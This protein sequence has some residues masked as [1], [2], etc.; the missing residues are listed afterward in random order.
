MG[1]LR[2]WRSTVTLRGGLMTA[3]G[4]L[5]A[6][7]LFGA[8]TEP[9]LKLGGVALFLGGVLAVHDGIFLPLVIASGALLTRAHRL[10][11]AALIVSLAVTVVALPFVLGYGRSPDNPSALPL[12]YGRG[13]LTVLIVIWTVTLTAIALLRR[14]PHGSRKWGPGR[15]SEDRKKTDHPSEAH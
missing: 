6:Y 14:L 7:A 11:R 9:G 15:S 3:G 5:M 10:V 2:R 4:L 8:L 13:L 12:A 1:L